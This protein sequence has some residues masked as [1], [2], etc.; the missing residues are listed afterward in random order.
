MK[1]FVYNVIK[2]HLISVAIQ[3]FKKLCGNVCV[4]AIKWTKACGQL[5]LK[6]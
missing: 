3:I 4:L 2:E 6:L 5:W 1:I